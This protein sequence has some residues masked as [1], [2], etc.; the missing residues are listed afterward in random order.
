VGDSI[1]DRIA[2]A[3]VEASSVVAIVSGSSVAS[4]W[5]RKELSLAMTSEVNA[6]T[7]K[8]LPAV[9]DNCTVP[10]SISDK[11]FADFR[12]GY[13]YGLLKLLEA[14]DSRARVEPWE[15]F[16]RLND[17]KTLQAELERVLLSGDLL[18]LRGWVRSRPQ[19]LLFLLG[20]L[21]ALSEVID[22]FAFGQAREDIEYLVASGQSYHFEF[23]AVRLGPVHW[24]ATSIPEMEAMAEATHRFVL[25]CRENYDE[26][27]RAASIRFAQDQIG[28]PSFVGYPEHFARRHEVRGTLLVGRRDQ[29]DGEYQRLRQEIYERTNGLIELASYDRLLDALTARHNRGMQ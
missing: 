6:R 17:S 21:W 11:F 27:A 24:R 25:N 15:R 19:V 16:R 28:P 23:Q 29:Y 12:E 3:V 20:R 26:F 18:E 1:I 10:P 4:Q 8:V 22:D 14:L 2:D 9:I 13:F 7:V 5:V